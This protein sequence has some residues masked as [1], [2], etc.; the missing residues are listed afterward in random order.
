MSNILPD[1]NLLHYRLPN[2]FNGALLGAVILKKV[3]KHDGILSNLNATM[4]EVLRDELSLEKEITLREK[5]FLSGFVGAMINLTAR[6]EGYFGDEAI[7]DYMGVA[8][9]NALVA[10]EDI[11][12]IHKDEI[13]KYLDYLLGNDIENKSTSSTVQDGKDP[14]GAFREDLLIIDYLSDKNKENK[15]AYSVIQDR[16]ERHGA[17]INDL[18]IPELEDLLAIHE[19]HVFEL[20]DSNQ[21][22]EIVLVSD[23]EKYIIDNLSKSNETSKNQI[24]AVYNIES[25]IETLVNNDGMN[26]DDAMD[27]FYFNID[28]SH[29][30][31]GSPFYVDAGS[32]K[33]SKKE[34]LRGIV[35]GDND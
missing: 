14:H 6:G 34:I 5:A 4:Y 33:S 27:W 3:E 18:L 7:L 25:I 19:G 30:G 13:N 31:S 21:L 2:E 10:R 16:Y 28:G 22:R 11:E 20:L 29:V 23:F 17:F 26:H 24:H 9:L 35:D 32:L 15:S 8:K 12:Q 1:V